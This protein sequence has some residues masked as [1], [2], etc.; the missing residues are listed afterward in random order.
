MKPV[1]EIL[2]L[3]FIMGSQDC[4]HD[5]IWTLEEAIKGGITC[6]QFREKGEHALAGEEMEALARELQARCKEYNIPFIINDD[7]ALA[8]K[9]DADGVHVGQDDTPISDVVHHFQGKYIGLSVHT[10]EEAIRAAQDQVDYIGVGPIFDTSTKKDAKK[11]SGVTTIQQIRKSGMTIPIVGIGGINADNAKSVM[12]AG[13]EGVSL[14]SAISQSNDPSSSA[15]T[16]RA[17]IQ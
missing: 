13:A 7:V 16:L 5:P 15:K 2:P 6:F 14:I 1:T 11:A 3:Y 4:T 10:L 17:A 8:Q 12:D 9:L